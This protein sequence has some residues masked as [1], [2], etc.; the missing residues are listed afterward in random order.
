MLQLWEHS[1]EKWP[2]LF[3]AGSDFRKLKL[4]L[5][6]YDILHVATVLSYFPKAR[7]DVRLREMV[8]TII[9]KADETVSTHPS[10][11]G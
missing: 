11:S 2:Y 6:W 8:D 9:G 7:G 4:P 1:R 10:R 5:V 3:H